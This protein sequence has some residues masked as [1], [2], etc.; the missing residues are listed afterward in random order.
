MLG[1]ASEG[2]RRSVEAVGRVLGESGGV[3]AGEREVRLRAVSWRTLRRGVPKRMYSLT[4]SAA[5]CLGR[6]V[7]GPK[8]VKLGP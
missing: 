3:L 4:C 1:A 6:G 8:H 2:E 7:G 5:L